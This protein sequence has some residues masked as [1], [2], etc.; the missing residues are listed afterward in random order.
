MRRNQ[1]NNNYELGLPAPNNYNFSYENRNDYRIYADIVQ[2]R[3]EALK[4]K[5]Q[6]YIVIIFVFV[7]LLL[8]FWVV[9]KLDKSKEEEAI[10][11]LPENYVCVTSNPDQYIGKNYLIASKEYEAMGY[12]VIECI[13][14]HDLIIGFFHH[15]GTTISISIGGNRNFKAGDIYPK[16]TPVT[17]VYHD[18][19]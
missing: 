4:M 15:P 9:G 8:F 12:T 5:F 6:L 18:F 10:E 17:I 19:S 2:S 14:E 13:P 1:E 16:D 11:N 7:F 3:N